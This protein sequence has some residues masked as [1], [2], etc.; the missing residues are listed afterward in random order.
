MKTGLSDSLA[1]QLISATDQQQVKDQ[2]KAITQEALDLGVT[3]L[4]GYCCCMV[5][6]L[7][8]HLVLLTLLLK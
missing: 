5:Y 1:D 8:R 3:W 6:H 7:H 4:I 2:L